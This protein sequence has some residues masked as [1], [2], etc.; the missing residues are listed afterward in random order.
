MGLPVMNIEVGNHVLAVGGDGGTLI[1]RVAEPAGD[2]DALAD[3]LGAD[4]P[5]PR[6]FDGVIVGLEQWTGHVETG[7]ELAQKLADGVALDD[8]ESWIG[9][10]LDLIERL[11]GSA[12]AKEALELA[13]TAQRVLALARRW[14]ELIKLLRGL[15]GSA[16]EATVAWAKH[17]LG[18]LAL[19]AGRLREANLSLEQA[20]TLR[21]AL[22]DRAGLT[23]TEQSLR[24][25]CAGLRASLHAPSRPRPPRRALLAAMALLLLLIGGVTGAAIADS[26]GTPAAASAD[27]TPTPA[28]TRTA[29]PTAPHRTP[30]AKPRTTA[31]PAGTA[32]P[33][34]TRTPRA[35]RTPTA[36]ATATP[37]ATAT[38]T[39]TAT[40]TP[41]EVPTEVPTVTEPT[42]APT[43]TAPPDPV[44]TATSAEPK[45][46]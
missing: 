2:A 38:A 8:L 31:T 26:D 29:T 16:D 25:L 11:D 27:E 37:T 6:P 3:A 10:A 20:H 7:A 32:A 28:T 17:E 5:R 33:T 12:R 41:T 23:A 24:V 4:V 15:L 39:A 14:L 21:R 34:A 44:P 46:R 9:P 43:E 19:A 35:T 42:V 36:T 13:R 22:G 45:L 40:D 18:T 1:T 30:T